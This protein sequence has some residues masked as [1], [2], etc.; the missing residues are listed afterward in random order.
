MDR[1]S[2]RRRS[3][4]D[5]YGEEPVKNSDELNAC[6]SIIRNPYCWYEV[7]TSN[8]LHLFIVNDRVPP[9]R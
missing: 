8:G 6:I 4:Q 2:L 1:W 3:R 5:D 9:L 7:G